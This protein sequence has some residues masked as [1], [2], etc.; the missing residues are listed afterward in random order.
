MIKRTNALILPLA[1]IFVISAA[2]L[3]AYAKDKDKNNKGKGDENKSEHALEIRQLKEANE[4]GSTLEVHIQDNGKVLVR[5]AKVTAIS[6]NTISAVT[7]W[8]SVILN[9]N[10][11][12]DSNTELVRRFGGISSVSEISVGDF[13][14]FNGILLTTASSPFT[15]QAKVL[16]DWSIQKKY[17]SFYGTVQ[18]IANGTQSFVLATEEKGNLTVVVSSSTK[19]KKGDVSGIFADL[20]VGQK[21]TVQG[22][23]NNL[24]NNLEADSVKIH[25]AGVTRT[26]IEGTFKTAASGTPPTTMILNSHSV[27]YT[28]NIS[29]DTSILNN[30][31]L[32]I[33]LAS[34]KVGDNV[35][36][37]GAVNTNNT[38]DATVI[39]DTSIKL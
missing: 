17:A 27:D 21:V 1:L 16:K 2:F 22:L 11:N 5:G 12:V 24:T 35:R 19:I 39:R 38:I 32:K 14:S 33:P 20:A 6:G 29:V 23:Y 25:L 9:W 31:W 15:V 8:G 26:T 4:I 7:A 36:V 3:P 10:I 37:Y 28:V 18:S 13:I 30:L 34:I